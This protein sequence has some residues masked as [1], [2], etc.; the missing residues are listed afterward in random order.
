MSHA[1]LHSLSMDR[2]RPGMA[3]CVELRVTA[4]ALSTP[5]HRHQLSL[6]GIIDFSAGVLPLDSNQRTNA[7]RRF[8]RIV[9]HFEIDDDNNPTQ[10][11]PPRLIRLTYEHALSEKSQDNFLRAFFLA[12]ALSIDEPAAEDDTEDLRSPFFGFADYLMDSF[13][14]PRLDKEDPTTLA[15]I[16]FGHRESAR[17][18]RIF[19]D[20]RSCIGSSRCLPRPRPSSLC[21]LAQIRLTRGGGPCP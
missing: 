21:Y 6:E 11:N 4:M 15:R 3:L 10:Y 12:L 13:Y 17:R 7:Q 8:Y 16:P 19:R 2:S 5:L 18:R 1:C 14:L 20:A 9:K